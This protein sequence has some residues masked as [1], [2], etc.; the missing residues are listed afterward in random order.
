MS[1]EL[2]YILIITKVL[3]STLCV[4][5]VFCGLWKVSELLFKTRNEQ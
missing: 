1:I 4:V 3:V 2:I 5:L